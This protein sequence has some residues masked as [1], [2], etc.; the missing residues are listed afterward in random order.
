M[1]EFGTVLTCMDGRIQ[2]KVSDYLLTS[3]GVRNLDTLTAA[4]M[5]R[6]LAADTERTATILGDLAISVTGHGSSQIAVAAHHDCAGNPVSDDAQRQEID[7]ALTRLAELYPDAELVGLW[8][9]K[10]WTLERIRAQG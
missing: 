2:R 8:L 4:G 9:D 3:F 6:H 5:V 10:H 7:K 1:R